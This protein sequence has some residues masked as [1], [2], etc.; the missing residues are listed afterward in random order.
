MKYALTV[1]SAL[2]VG[3]AGMGP[4]INTHTTVFHRLNDVSL[5]DTYTVVPWNK[6]LNGSLE[7]G[8][9]A[10]QVSAVLKARGFNV[11]SPGQPAKY[12]VFLDYGIDDGRTVSQ[13]YSI[14][15]FGVTGSSGSTTTGTIN[16][17]G[18]TSYLNATTTKTPTYGVTGYIQ[19]TSNQTVFRRFVNM[20]IVDLN[21]KDRL[22]RVYQLQL[23]SE[24]LCGALA[25]VMPTF[26]QVISQNLTMQSGSTKTDAIGWNGHC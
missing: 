24:G 6:E 8:Q 1:L 14:P 5:Q 4:A 18:S 17:Y 25:S 3:C 26:M 2:L 22:Q 21:V 11:V 15:Q 19:G 10:E 12:A 20:D 16:T 7:F 23:K 13:S 9:Y